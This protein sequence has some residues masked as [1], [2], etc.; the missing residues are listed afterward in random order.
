M[1]HVHTYEHGFIL[2]FIHLSNILSII[3][4]IKCV[5]IVQILVH[6]FE[7]GLTLINIHISIILSII[8]YIIKGILDHLHKLGFISTY[9]YLSTHIGIISYI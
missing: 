7:L 5:N 8:S 6:T 4:F 9:N 2:I 3:S 1:I